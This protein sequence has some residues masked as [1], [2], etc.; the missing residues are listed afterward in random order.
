MRKKAAW[1][2]WLY[3]YQIYLNCY[4]NCKEKQNK[5]LGNSNAFLMDILNSIIFST[6]TDINGSGYVS[7]Q[8]PKKLF[9][10]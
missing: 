7:E 6:L 10:S 8:Q 9:T 3:D 1:I 2:T 5:C 4:N